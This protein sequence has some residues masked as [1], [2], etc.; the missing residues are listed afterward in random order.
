MEQW[1]LKSLEYAQVKELLKKQAA[2]VLGKEKVDQLMPEAR[3][4]RVKDRLDSTQEG[5]DV[6]RLKGDVPFG[7][8]RDIRASIRRAEMEGMLSETECL[9]VAS[10]ISAGRKIKSFLR[11]IEEEAA[12]LPIL[13]GLTEQVASLDTI[14]KEILRSIDEQAVVKDQASP[15][16]GK[17]RSQIGEA[18]KRIN[19]ILQEM[20]RNPHY[21][22]MMQEAIITQRFDRY[23]IPVKME[24]RSRFPGIVHDQSSSGATLFIEPEAV[25]KWNNRLRELELSG[26][27]EVEKVLRRLTGVIGEEAEALRKN[28]E[29]LAELD[30][31]MACARFGYQVKGVVPRISRSTL[32]LKKARHPLI[33]AKDVV[34]I[35]LEMGESYQAIIITGPNTGGK[36]VTLKTVGLFA[37]M[38]QSG[39][40]IPAEE[41]SVMPVFSGV[42]AD[43]GDEQS[44][45]QNLSTFSGHLTNII[46]ILKQIDEKSLVLFDELGAGTDPTEGAALAIAIL[47]HVIH[48]GCLVMATTHYSEL[49][50]FAHTHPNAINASVEF[51]VQTLKPTYRLLIGVPGSSNAFSISKRLGLPDEL[52]QTARAQLS[53]D[54]NRME[55]M[56]TFLTEERKSAEEDRYQAE[57]LRIEAEALY[58]D[59]KQKWEQL[60][61]EKARIKEKA[62]CEAQSII[63][64]AE[65]E[66]EEVVKKLQSWIKARPRDLKEHELIDARTRLKNAVPD[67][68][69]PQKQKK[70]TGTREALHVG[71]EVLV[72]S[73]NQTGT[74]VD[75]L[76]DGFFQVQVGFLK[77]KIHKDQLEKRSSP[78]PAAAGKT[79]TTIKRAATDVKPECDIRGKLVEEALIEVDNYLDKAILAG[80]KQVFLIHGKGTGAL[81]AGVQEYLRHQRH[82]K[83]FRLGNHGEGGSGVTVVELK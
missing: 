41:E 13:R 36:T 17:I 33:N 5:M 67:W 61:E 7:G 77:M 74:I 51:D 55:E 43:I 1:T 45:E 3:M 54:E 40:P 57:K 68:E 78:K 14:E 52:I 66:A 49:K 20:I 38:T 9:D 47:E 31:I 69:W 79:G 30:L 58:R 83:S 37:L 48:R 6:I 35:D 12:T 72:L 28:T 8:V 11:Q 21:T 80:Y 19:Q 39:I 76:G 22:K 62:R 46:R 81:R 53:T 73:V 82:V 24:Y 18:R 60:E 64:K 29:I 71:D 70:N 63:K 65:R 26:K 56:I 44:I 75:E 15:G 25:V 16:L 10:T 23:V 42:Y 50:L 27:K 2:T 34:P 4:E 32:K 59:L